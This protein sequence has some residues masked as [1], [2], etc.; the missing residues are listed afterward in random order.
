MRCR[1]TAACAAFAARHQAGRG[2]RFEAALVREL[3]ARARSAVVA[4]MCPIYAV[5]AA[6]LA[7]PLGVPLVLWFTH[8]QPSRLLRPP[9]ASRPRCVSVDDGPSR[10]RRGSCVAIGH[11]ID[12][13]R[14][15]CTRRAAAAGLRLLALG[16]YSAAKGLDSVIRAVA[17]ARDGR[18]SS[19]VHGPR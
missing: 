7:R 9:S 5:L 15:P 3:A 16:R 1:R 17:L 6:P 14:V 2:L 12:L 10:S 4:H 11:G 8:W 13:A 19:S 18:P